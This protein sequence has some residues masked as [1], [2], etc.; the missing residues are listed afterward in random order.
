MSRAADRNLIADLFDRLCDLSPDARAAYLAEHDLPSAV[1]AELNSLLMCDIEDA[2]FLETPVSNWGCSLLGAESAKPVQVPG[3]EIVRLLGEGGMGSVWEARQLKPIQRPVA[4]KVVKSHFLFDRDALFRRFRIERQ[5]LAQMNHP[6]IAQIYGGGQTDNGEPYLLMEFVEQGTPLLA[7][8]RDQRL[9]LAERLDLFMQVCRGVKHAHQKGIIH[10]DLKP[11]NILVKILDKKPVVKIIDF[12]IA[13]QSLQLSDAGAQPQAKGVL[14]GTPLYMAPEQADLDQLDIDTQTDVYAL[15]VILY[16]LVADQTPFAGSPPNGAPL[17]DVCTYIAEKRPRA[18]RDLA[19]TFSDDDWNRRARDLNMRKAAVSRLFRGDLSAVLLKG[20]ATQRQHRY[21][22]VA[23][24]VDDVR[25]FCDHRP[26]TARTASTFYIAQ[27]FVRRNRNLLG[28]AALIFVSL[29]SALITTSI[30]LI[31]LTRTQEQV[32]SE[33]RKNKQINEFLGDIFKS[34][35]PEEDGNVDVLAMLQRVGR[36]WSHPLYVPDKNPEVRASMHLALGRAYRALNH[37]N[38]AEAQFQHAV[39]LLGETLGNQSPEYLQAL[40]EHA[41]LLS[42]TEQHGEA[43]NLF[44]K[45]TAWNKLTLG[46]NHHQTIVA[47]IHLAGCYL[48]Q[49]DLAKAERLFQRSLTQAEQ[50]LNQHQPIVGQCK[51]SLALT[52]IKRQQYD[53]AEHMLLALHEQEKLRLPESHPDL[54]LNL[55][56]LSLAVSRGNDSTIDA[57]LDR[58]FSNPYWYA[59][60]SSRDQEMAHWIETGDRALNRREFNK[61]EKFYSHA[62]QMG[63]DIFGREHLQTQKA[64]AALS[65]ALAFQ[66]KHSETEAIARDHEKIARMQFG[67]SHPITLTLRDNLSRAL[68]AQGKQ[69]EADMMLQDN[70]FADG[71]SNETKFA[72]LRESNE[73]AKLYLEQNRFE[74]AEHLAQRNLAHCRRL[75]SQPNHPKM[76]P[77]LETLA[78]IH[79]RRGDNDAGNQ[80]LGE[81]VAV[82]GTQPLL[83]RSLEATFHN[84]LKHWRHES[85]PTE[86]SSATSGHTEPVPFSSPTFGDDLGETSPVATGAEAVTHAP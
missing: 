54:M 6:N 83:Y 22:S 1:V 3:C 30:S 50:H 62:Y 55:H 24:L 65:R 39:Q 46:D 28:I 69:R 31:R 60:P 74:Q 61:A 33:S 64:A 59:M 9:S 5:T 8:C 41:V 43:L 2:Q 86:Q 19:K 49:D 10:R 79:F 15:S 57:K 45:I 7:Y 81:A 53:T 82:A 71:P 25:A 75:V 21:E 76:L 51:R 48:K 67:H 80:I 37:F 16:Q 84:K 26:V 38:L 20:L 36:H 11:A 12:G 78:E 13:A 32:L 68:L 58:S 44:R 77:F 52:L 14:A 85:N 18:L 72:E 34:A 4:I 42:A 73:I 63:I 29:C 47:Q 17:A 23:A 56:L 27:R 35:V 70:L 66:G 40:F